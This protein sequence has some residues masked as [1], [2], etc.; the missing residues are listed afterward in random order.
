MIQFSSRKLL[1]PLSGVF[2]AVVSPL[3]AQDT[4][5]RQGLDRLIE[6][7]IAGG[8]HGLYFL[9]TCGEGPSLSH[10]LRREVIKLASDR[11]RGRVPVLIGI[12]DTSF[13]ESVSLAEIA[14][15]CRATAAVISAP[16]FFP[17]SQPE[18][19]SYFRHLHDELPLPMVLHNSPSITKTWI[20]P[21]TLEQLIELPKLI[22]LKDSSADVRY[23][24]QVIS[25]ARKY[26][27]FSVL[28]GDDHRLGE[29]IPRGAVGAMLGGANLFP[30]LFVGWFD[31]VHSGDEARAAV[32]QSIADQ[33]QSIYR[34]GQSQATA[35]KALKA[36]L[37]YLNI[38]GDLAAEPFQPFE[39]AENAAVASI[40]EGVEQ[41][42]HEAFEAVS[43]V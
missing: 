12:S 39:E 20:E 26:S 25:I 1:Q 40:L 33:F 17:P 42:L 30:Q 3:L 27:R 11:V 21:H 4:L 36:G 10:R 8:I 22:G 43:L 35:V 31:A 37:A 23:L 19:I 24:E 15:D 29:S 34:V 28:I 7:L 18:L 6:H 16:H 32:Y 13:S 5:D 38:C 9:G 41:Q 2:P 14:H